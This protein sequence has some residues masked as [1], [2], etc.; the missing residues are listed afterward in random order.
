MATSITPSNSIDL[1][2]PQQ[3]DTTDKELFRQL[4]IVYGAL[5]QLQN[6]V[7]AFLDIPGHQKDA[8]YIINYL[9]RGQSIDTNSSVT[10]PDET[11]PDFGY[12]FTLGTT[13]S[14]VNT[15]N[16][17]ISVIQD[18]NVTIILAG[19]STVGTRTLNGWGVAA[20][21]KIGTNAWVCWGSGVS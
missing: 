15:S 17:P 21:R 20:V 1:R 4:S 18:V 12:Q 7:D 11:N 19:T 2:L 8:P 5:R 6:G 16:S 13:V 3:P 9:D 14:I 10:I